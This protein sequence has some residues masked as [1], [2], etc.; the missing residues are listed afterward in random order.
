METRPEARSAS[1]PTQHQRCDGCGECYAG[2]LAR[3]TSLR[4]EQMDAN[5]QYPWG[6][7]Q[8]LPTPGTER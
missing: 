7:S 4:Y 5:G 2:G 6:M 1:A 3:R 8:P